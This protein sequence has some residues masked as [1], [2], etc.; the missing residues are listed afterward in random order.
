MGKNCKAPSSKAIV[1]R[2]HSSL[3]TNKSVMLRLITTLFVSALL[4]VLLG[5]GGAASSGSGQIRFIHLV[6]DGPAF[7][8]FADFAVDPLASNRVFKE[9]GGYQSVKSLAQN[10][11]VFVAGTS[12]V[13]ASIPISP[14]QGERLSLLM[15]GPY[16]GVG[17]L[18]LGDNVAIPSSGNVKLRLVMA[19]ASATSVDIYITAPSDPLPSTPNF[20]NVA[21]GGQTGFLELL[22]GSYRI[23]VTNSTNQT[24][25]LDS[26]TITL[27]A[28]QIKTWAAVDKDGGGTPLQG[29]L[30]NN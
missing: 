21:F 9:A 16:S 23:R 18:L 28:G 29:V 19:A 6:A 15:V 25:L 30:Y 17:Y 22:A 10:V 4:F 3:T 24:V 26:G 12:N 27:A 1:H 13:V 14:G 5:C 8:A 2:S 11:D 7:D 20:D